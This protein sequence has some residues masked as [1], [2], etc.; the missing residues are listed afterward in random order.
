MNNFSVIKRLELRLIQLWVIVI[1]FAPILFICGIAIF[2]SNEDF[3]YGIISIGLSLIFIVIHL[4]VLVVI[5]DKIRE[6]KSYNE[7]L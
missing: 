1:I 7:N 3:R 2:F 4:L 6:L 5:K